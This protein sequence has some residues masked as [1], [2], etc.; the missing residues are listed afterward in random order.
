LLQTLL[1]HGLS[2]VTDDAIPQCTA[3][4][5]IV[6]VGR[7]E[8][9]RY[10]MTFIHEVSMELD[11]SHRRHVDIRDQA[12]RLEKTRGREEIGCRCEGLNSM[13]QRSHEPPHGL[14]K[15]FII[16]NDRDQ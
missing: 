3:P 16:F 1:V 2:K 11:A 5:I 15:E 10:G 13:T 7:Q 6:S 8:N 4:D 12:G 9:G 14:T